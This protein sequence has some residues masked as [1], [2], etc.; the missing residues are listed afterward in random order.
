LSKGHQKRNLAIH[1]YLSMELLNQY[2]VNTPKGGVARTPQEAFEVAKK[3]GTEDAV[4]KAQVLAGGRG[5]GVF[6]SG[7][8]GG[9]RPIFS[10]TEAEKFAKQMLGH[11]LITKQTGSAGKICNSVYIVERK[12][13]RREYYFAILQDRKTQGPV[14]VASSQGG[15]DIESVAAENPDAILTLGVD[16]N[17]GLK[18]DDALSLAEKLGFSPK[19]RD[20]AADM[21][22][23]L[24][25]LFIDKD[26]TQVEINPMAESVEHEV[27]CMDAKLNFDDNSEF[28]QKDIFALRDTSQED[29]REVAAAKYNL[30]YIGLEGRIGLNGAG[31]AMSTMD[32]IKLHGGEPANFLD[33]GGGATAEQVTEAFK[34]ISSDPQVTA[35][36]VNIFGGIMRCDIIAQGII[37]A[38]SQLSLTIPVIVRLQGTEVNAAK[39]LIA[40]SG[41][42][43]ISVDDLDEAASKSVQLSKIV[44]IAREANIRVSFE[45]PI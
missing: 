17:V 6:E 9:V 4:I 10:P 37:Q 1:E 13:V 3:L 32:I 19:I 15:V 24:Y 35:I 20:E 25:K 18:K 38:T 21:M 42:R 39:K 28:R 29:P 7:L 30:N 11:K 5:K 45:L 14:I 26:C 16:I 23:K 36:L 12:F 40:E 2:G 33:V 34:I 27:L 44:D 22:Q 43:I 8:K 31:L 41:L